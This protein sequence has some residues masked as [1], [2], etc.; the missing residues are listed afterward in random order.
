MQLFW[1]K[2]F[3]VDEVPSFQR[4]DACQQ[5][6]FAIAR[7][8]LWIL[9]TRSADNWRHRIEMLNNLDSFIPI[10]WKQKMKQ[11][12]HLHINFLLDASPP[13]AT[14]QNSNSLILYIFIYVNAVNSISIPIK[15]IR[16]QFNQIDKNFIHFRFH[17]SA[18]WHHSFI[19]AKGRRMQRISR[20]ANSLSLRSMKNRFV[21]ESKQINFG[22]TWKR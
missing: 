5:W 10:S 4:G 14:Q 12:K 2:D 7:K 18:N 3:C 21:F 17:L 6:M 15:C 13:A 1:W 19:F 16:V 11:S 20:C 9:N 8:F 22:E